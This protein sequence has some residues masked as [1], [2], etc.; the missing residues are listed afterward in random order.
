MIRGPFFECRDWPQLGIRPDFMT[1]AIDWVSKTGTGDFSAFFLYKISYVGK[2]AHTPDKLGE[3]AAVL[4]NILI[5]VANRRKP[6]DAA[7][8]RPPAPFAVIQWS[9]KI[10]KNIGIDKIN[11][12]FDRPKK[13]DVR[14]PAL[15]LAIDRFH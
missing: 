12:V 7:Q 5:D 8:I 10:I 1:T 3:K 11:R 9:R 4:V 14:R 13:T 6:S 15:R 2:L